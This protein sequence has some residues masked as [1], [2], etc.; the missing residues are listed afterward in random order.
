M[1]KPNQYETLL[2]TYLQEVQKKRGFTNYK[3]AKLCKFERTK[4]AR[5]MSGQQSP[6]LGSL[7]AIC[8]VLGVKVDFSTQIEV[9][10][11]GFT[12]HG[13]NDKM[14]DGLMFDEFGELI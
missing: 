9:P 4:V 7:F 8:N 6:T 10:S 1:P 11:L 12:P 13:W 2:I 14:P 3:I 5:I